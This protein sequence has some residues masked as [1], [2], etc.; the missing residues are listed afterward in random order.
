MSGA[1]FLNNRG[2][3]VKIKNQLLLT[4]GLLVVLALAVV[5][6]NIFAYMDMENDA[7]IINQAGKLRMLSYNMAHLS[8][9][10]TTG[11]DPVHE[12]HLASNLKLKIDEFETTLTLLSGKSVDSISVDHP[13]TAIKLETIS[14][15]W[16]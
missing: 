8:N 3:F 4:H 15:E 2:D 9:Q 10:I 13:Q 11:N 1:A 5:F 12:E 16:G 6:I 7:N 14:K